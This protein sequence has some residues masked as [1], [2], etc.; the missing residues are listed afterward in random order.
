MVDGVLKSSYLLL[1]VT[2]KRLLGLRLPH[3]GKLLGLRLPHYHGSME[4]PLYRFTSLPLYWCIIKVIQ[5][6]SF[7]FEYVFWINE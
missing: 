3:Y 1:T 5:I 2:S 7:G 6:I 4:T